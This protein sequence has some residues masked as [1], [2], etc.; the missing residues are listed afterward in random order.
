MA[1]S[2]ISLLSVQVAK[3]RSL[4]VADRITDSGIGKLPVGSASIEVDGLVG[5]TVADT[6][7]HGGRDQAV[8]VYSRED[9]AWWEE[10]L[11]RSLAS[12]IFGENL[13]ISSFG[14]DEV[15]IGDRWQIGGVVLETTAPRIPCG[16]LGAVMK[17]PN[18]VKT[19]R[20]ARRPGFYARVINP[21]V[22][23]PGTEVT[24]YPFPSGVSL[25]DLFDL[26]Y[27][28]D[29]PAH[30]LQRVL[31][32]PIAERARRNTEDRLARLT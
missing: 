13:T 24:R 17:D 7:H 1:G 27:D 26:V 5:D 19:F 32:A 25:L 6:R 23:A 29:A 12:G 30:E 15:M 16:K 28:V 22:V 4:V 18:F 3:R 11:G 31:G 10:Q 9:Y 8:Y 14:G 2:T 21:G 20:Q